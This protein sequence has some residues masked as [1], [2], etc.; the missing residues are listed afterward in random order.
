MINVVSYLSDALITIFL[1][2]WCHSTYWYVVNNWSFFFDFQILM[3]ARTQMEEC[4]LAYATTILEVSTAHVLQATIWY[5]A[6]C[7]EVCFLTLKWS[8]GVPMDPKISF[9]GSAWK[10]RISWRRCFL[11]FTCLPPR[12]FWHVFEKKSCSASR[13]NCVSVPMDPPVYH[14]RDDTRQK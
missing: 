7:A 1:S 2:G 8:R 5:K 13:G 9:L 3:N 10:R 12:I 4:V 14:Q 6:E 11:T